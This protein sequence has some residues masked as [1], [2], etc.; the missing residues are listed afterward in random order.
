MVSVS[1]QLQIYSGL[2]GT[3]VQTLRG[4]HLVV[5]RYVLMVKD[6]SVKTC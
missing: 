6:D 2:D 1:T 5:H 3:L 4:S